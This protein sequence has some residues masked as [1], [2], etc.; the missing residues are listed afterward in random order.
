MSGADLLRVSLI[1]AV[2]LHG[3]ANVI[4][5]C[6]LHRVKTLVYTSTVNAV[7]HGQ[8]LDLA[9]EDEVRRTLLFLF[10]KKKS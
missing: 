9:S 6:E 7:F 5:S 3:T 4:R 1:K 8:V 2:N 10:L